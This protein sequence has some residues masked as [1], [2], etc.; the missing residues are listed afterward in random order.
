M[1]TG[2]KRRFIY[3][4]AT[5]TIIYYGVSSATTV[6]ESIILSSFT[7]ITGNVG[8]PTGRYYKFESVQKYKYWCIPDV[9][10]IANG[11]KV[12]NYIKHLEDDQA[13][14]F[15]YNS[16]YSNIQTDPDQTDI[17]EVNYGLLNINGIP[18][19]LY[20]DVSNSSSYT[21]FN[22]YSF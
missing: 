8:T 6:N 11:D 12:I 22:V 16:F 20:R 15:A 4:E 1:E 17:Q 3:T 18:Y 9:S 10:G 13:L 7:G 14:V 19:R 5:P 21:E 2:L